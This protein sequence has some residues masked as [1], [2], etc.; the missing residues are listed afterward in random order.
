M[1]TYMLPVLSEVFPVHEEAGLKLRDFSRWPIFEWMRRAKRVEE[2]IKCSHLETTLF[3]L[4][5]SSL[6]DQALD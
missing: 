4:L 6:R 5:F 1:K 3:F 2:D